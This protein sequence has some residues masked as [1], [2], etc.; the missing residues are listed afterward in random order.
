MTSISF[1]VTDWC[2]SAPGLFTPEEWCAWA[3][4]GTPVNPKLPLR[5]PSHLSPMT[6][7]RLSKG[8]RLAVECALEAAGEIA[9]SYVIFASRHAELPRNEKLL[10]ALALGEDVSPADFTMSVHNAAAG[11]LTIHA[12]SRAPHASIAAGADT[13]AAALAEAAAAMADGK[14]TVLLAAFENELPPV[15]G[16]SFALQTGKWPW[17][18]AFLLEPGTEFTGAASP[19]RPAEPAEEPALQFLRGFLSGASSFG[20]ASGSAFWRWS[21]R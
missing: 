21:R 12:K 9:P 20:V 15:L 8:A 19:A 2:A 16:S 1:S 3:A 18:A 14:K 7:R 4:S 13:F 10:T 5:R 6:G 17:A 11:S